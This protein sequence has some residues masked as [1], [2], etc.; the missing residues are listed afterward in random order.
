MAG[1]R[2]RTPRRSAG[3]SVTCANTATIPAW[4]AAEADAL[5]ALL[6]Q[7][8]IPEFY[9]R[10]EKG[11]PV[12]WVAKMRESMA[13]LT[14]AFSANRVV[15]QYTEEHYLPA[16]ANYAA[17][18]ANGGR[19]G[20]DLLNWQKQMSKHWSTLRFGSAAVT[21]QGD[22]NFFQVQVYLD[23][24]DPEAVKVEL[25]AEGPNGAA[26]VREAMTRGERLVGAA[27][28]FTYTARF[29]PRDP[30]RTTRRD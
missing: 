9:T 12:S 24:L 1:G 20:V 22:H 7:Q 29:P 16:A 4:D 25:Y 14:P 10:N 21:R 18:A 23:D 3:Q 11:I 19:L 8:V 13:R 28:G 17:R 5:Y 26:P 15:R 2:K 30:P 27:N 6:E